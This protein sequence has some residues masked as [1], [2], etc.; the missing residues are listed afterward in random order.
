VF[1]LPLQ[2]Y[3]RGRGQLLGRTFLLLVHT[4]RRTGSPHQTVAMVLGDDRDTGELVICS[5]WG[6]DTDWVKNLR[7]RPAVR[8]QIGA[9]SFTPTHRFLTDDQAFAIACEFRRRH[10]WRLRLLARILGWGD[11]SSDTNVTRFIESHPF[12]GLRPR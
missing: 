6:R 2:L 3:R 7:A 1:R 10:P 11:L 5:A 12:I 9:D 4:G 8:V